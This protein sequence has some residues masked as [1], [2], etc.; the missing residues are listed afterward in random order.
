M[1][2]PVVIAALAA[3]V[4][5][6]GASSAPAHSP[7]GTGTFF[8]LRTDQRL[9]PGPACGGW[10]ASLACATGLVYLIRRSRGGSLTDPGRV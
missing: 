9:C 7:H 4:S 8:Q 3:L 2:V 10:L 5:L 6:A 1:R